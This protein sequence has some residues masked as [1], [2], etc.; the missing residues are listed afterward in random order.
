[1]EIINGISRPVLTAAAGIS[2]SSGRIV[3]FK[4]LDEQ[5]LLLLW[6]NPGNVIIYPV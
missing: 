1:M 2:I 4:F 3:D 6:L 5:S